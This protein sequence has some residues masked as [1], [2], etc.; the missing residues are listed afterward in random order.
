MLARAGT[1]RPNPLRRRLSS[2]APGEAQFA[3]VCQKCPLTGYFHSEWELLECRSRHPHRNAAVFVYSFQ[4]TRH[5]VSG[6]TLHEYVWVELVNSGEID[7][8]ISG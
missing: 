5:S 6:F 7:L 3:M 2:R 8:G 1:L 4:P